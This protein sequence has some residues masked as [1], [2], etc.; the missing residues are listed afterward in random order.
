MWLQYFRIDSSLLP[1]L[2]ENVPAASPASPWAP[3]TSAADLQV[4]FCPDSISV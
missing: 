3:I 2:Q 1:N 4:C